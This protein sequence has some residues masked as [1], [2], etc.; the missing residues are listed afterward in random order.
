[1]STVLWERMYPFCPKQESSLHVPSVTAGGLPSSTNSRHWGQADLTNSDSGLYDISSVKMLQ[2]L[3]GSC[4]QGFK[5]QELGVSGAETRGK[6]SK[7]KPVS[8]LGKVSVD[9]RCVWHTLVTPHLCLLVI[10]LHVLSCDKVIIHVRKNAINVNNGSLLLTD[11]F[12]MK[13]GNDMSGII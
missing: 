7:K 4:V 12:H 3:L 13:K 2:N 8:I 5:P 1:M 10:G 6:V 9:G 11:F